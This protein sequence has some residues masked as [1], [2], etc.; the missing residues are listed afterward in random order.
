MVIT[1]RAR[2]GRGGGAGAPQYLGVR[3]GQD[4][5]E[6]RGGR[7]IDEGPSRVRG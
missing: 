5:D 7:R 4:P 2:G 3:R 6:R 1:S